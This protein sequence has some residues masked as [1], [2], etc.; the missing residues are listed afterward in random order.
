[1]F[2]DW[3]KLNFSLLEKIDLIKSMIL[4]KFLFLFQNLP[5]EVPMKAFRVETGT[6]IYPDFYGTTK[7]QE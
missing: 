1:M 4:P 6:Q 5:I 2:E 3:H 7:G